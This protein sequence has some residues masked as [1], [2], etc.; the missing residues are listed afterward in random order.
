MNTLHRHIPIPFLLPLR[1]LLTFSPYHRVPLGNDSNGPIHI[2]INLIQLDSLLPY[3]N[4]LL[5]CHKQPKPIQT[6]HIPSRRLHH[7]TVPV[8]ALSRLR[9]RTTRF[10]LASCLDPSPPSRPPQPPSIR[11]NHPIRQLPN[12]SLMVYQGQREVCRSNLL[13]DR[14]LPR[15]LPERLRLL[16]AQLPQMLPPLSLSRPPR[17]DTCDTRHSSSHPSMN[18]SPT[19]SDL[20]LPR[21]TAPT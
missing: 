1:L 16:P 7:G 17:L 21:A 3:L 12:Q 14:L 11:V 8:N 15:S 6:N 9:L 20:A 5:K 10:S 4:P 18:A 13:L 19:S 2:R